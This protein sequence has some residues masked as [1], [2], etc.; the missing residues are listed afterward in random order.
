M[1]NVTLLIIL[2]FVHVNPVTKAMHLLAVL[3]FHRVSIIYDVHG[4][5]L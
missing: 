1:L 5:F 4:F 2:H 3:E